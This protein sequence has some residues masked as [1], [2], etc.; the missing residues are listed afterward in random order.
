MVAAEDD[1][2]DHRRSTT[3]REKRNVVVFIVVTVSVALRANEKVVT[4]V[5]VVFLRSYFF[6]TRVCK[7]VTL[8]QSHS[9]MISERVRGFIVICLCFLFILAKLHYGLQVFNETDSSFKLFWSHISFSFN[10]SVF[11]NNDVVK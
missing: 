10:P 8:L 2:G 11:Q 3:A 9:M 1:G 4:I 7:L 6:T 5:I